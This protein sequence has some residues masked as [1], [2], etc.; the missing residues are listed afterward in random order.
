MQT[1]RKSPTETP[2][3]AT[4]PVATSSS[5]KKAALPPAAKATSPTKAIAPSTPAPKVTD[6]DAIFA[7]PET[8]QTAAAEEAIKKMQQS[9]ATF[10]ACKY[11]GGLAAGQIIEVGP[12]IVSN[13]LETPTAE[14]FKLMGGFNIIVTVKP[15]FPAKPHWLLETVADKSYATKWSRGPSYIAKTLVVGIGSHDYPA[16]T[17]ETIVDLLRDIQASGTYSSINHVSVDLTEE[18]AEDLMTKEYDKTVK[19]LWEAKCPMKRL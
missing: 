10:V 2:S 9:K 19:D 5:V 4:A 16:P 13:P 8:P 6:F 1:K 17:K 15:L 12:A 14:K 7:L 18:Q 11:K 3:T